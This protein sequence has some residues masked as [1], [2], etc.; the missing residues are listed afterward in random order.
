MPLIEALPEVGASSVARILTS[1][2]FP[3]PF[4]PMRAK[5]PEDGAERLTSR[6]AVVAPPY[7]FVSFSVTSSPI[8]V[9]L[10]FR[11]QTECY[12]RRCPVCGISRGLQIPRQSYYRG[13]VDL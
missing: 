1:V 6:R 7:R 4:L 12:F 9:V 11:F 10:R 3:A 5:M 13:N 2:V 8:S